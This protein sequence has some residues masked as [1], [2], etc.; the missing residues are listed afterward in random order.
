MVSLSTLELL[1]AS[2]KEAQLDVVDGR[3]W[4]QDWDDK[5]VAFVDLIGIAA[6]SKNHPDVTVNQIVRFHRA[7]SAVGAR[8]PAVRLLRFTDAAY[9]TSADLQALVKFVSDLQHYCLAMSVLARGR[10]AQ[11]GRSA[12]PK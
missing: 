8:Y 11:P 3:Q 9:A 1:A 4:R 7:V 5:W 12:R 6:R 2:I 10:R